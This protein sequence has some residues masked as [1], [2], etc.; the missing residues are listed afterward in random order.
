MGLALLAGAL[1]LIHDRKYLLALMPTALLS[2]TRPGALAL[3]LALGL[4]FSDRLW[5]ARKNPSDFDFTERIQLFVAG[6]VTAL[7]GFAWSWIAWLATGRSD[8]YMSTELAWRAGYTGT[9][10]FVPFQSWLISANW[11]LPGLPGV[12]VL[13]ALVGLVVWNL[14]SRPMVAL[15]LTM[16]SWTAAYWVYLFVFFYPQSSTFRI[17]LPAFPMLA[18]LGLSTQKASRL[19]KVGIVV[20]FTVLQLCWLLTCWMY[21]APDFTPP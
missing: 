17:L 4:I 11:N 7:F 9:Q 3:A 21:T 16:R 5:R 12:L 1:L 19:A 2:V 10:H 18:A 20:S 15:G 6:I 13:V 14:F 8:A